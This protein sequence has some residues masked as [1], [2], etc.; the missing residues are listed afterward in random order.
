MYI[1]ISNANG[2][3]EESNRNKYLTQGPSDE[4][5][6]KLKKMKIQFNTSWKGWK[7]NSIQMMIYP[8]KKI[9]FYDTII[10]VRSVFN[11]GNQTIQKFS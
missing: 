3:I 4:S 5:K 2:Y 6:Y 11:D 7:F 10:V 9:K 1:L 8:Q